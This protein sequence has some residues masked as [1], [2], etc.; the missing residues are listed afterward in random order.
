MH[1]RLPIG[2]SVILDTA[3]GGHIVDLAVCA[4]PGHYCKCGVYPTRVPKSWNSSHSIHPTYTFL[5]YHQ[6]R[7]SCWPKLRLSFGR[8]TLSGSILL[9]FTMD[10]SM[11]LKPVPSNTTTTP[12]CSTASS[13]TPPNPYA[14]DSS[15]RA[16]ACVTC[17]K[18][19]TRCDKAV[20]RP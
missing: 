8:D 11:K 17:A 9:S 15:R 10:Q 12:S 6:I 19:K 1:F 18:A 5:Y 7:A 3:P 20:G 14:R 13:Y 2:Y 16:I 4:K